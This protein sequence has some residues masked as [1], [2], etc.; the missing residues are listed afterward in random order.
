MRPHPDGVE[1]ITDGVSTVVV[2]P[3]SAGAAPR[4]PPVPQDPELIGINLDGFLVIPVDDPGPP[5]LLLYLASAPLVA[6]PDGEGHKPSGDP[7]EVIDL[8]LHSGG[9]CALGP[10]SFAVG[11]G[12]GHVSFWE[13]SP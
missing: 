8:E 11:D 2:R 5:Q 9:L 13:L 4:E 6:L 3:P 1:V 10:R 12:D 7:V